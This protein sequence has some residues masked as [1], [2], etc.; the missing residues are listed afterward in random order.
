MS[1]VTFT[2][3]EWSRIVSILDLSEK[4]EPEAR[5]ELKEMRA[6]ALQRAS[7]QRQRRNRAT[8][9]LKAIAKALDAL[10]KALDMDARE[11]DPYSMP[12]AL[13]LLAHAGMVPEEVRQLGK[14]AARMRQL[15]SK[16]QL[17]TVTLKE[18]NQ[19]TVIRDLAPYFMRRTGKPATSTKGGN[20]CALV[21]IVLGLGG[22]AAADD[23]RASELIRAA[24]AKPAKAAKTRARTR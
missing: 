15:V 8:K 10:G 17:G 19:L 14:D 6:Y 13:A 24:L 23:G 11:D 21:R 22:V 9:D 18:Q 3:D 2:P 12:Y 1:R 20:F 4:E 7:E 5:R 16:A